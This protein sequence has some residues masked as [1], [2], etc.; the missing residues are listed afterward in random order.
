MSL[1]FDF[2]KDDIFDLAGKITAHSYR[3]EKANINKLFKNINPLDYEIISIL[4]R[5]SEKNETGKKFYLSDMSE[6]IG[7]PIS[8][9]SRIVRRL[10]DKKL[11]DWKHDGD[12]NEGTYICITDGGL[13]AAR[14]QHERL[15]KFYIGVVEEFGRDRF[16]SHLHEMA[17][18]DGIMQKRLEDYPED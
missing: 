16:L 13:T 2:K 4:A 8:R 11:V 18:L 6:Q 9:V 15:E 7:L 10:Y 17:E 12:G 5:E 14:D 1:N 3:I